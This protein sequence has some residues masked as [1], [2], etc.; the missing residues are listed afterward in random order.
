MPQTTR[1]TA[2]AA[3]LATPA[4]APSLARAQ[5][6]AG[7][8]W[9]TQTVRYINPYPPGGSTDILSRLFCARLSELTGQQFVV[10]NRSGSGGD[11]GLDAVAKSRPDGLTLGLGGIA[12]QAI[13]PTLKPSLPFHPERDFTFVSGIWQLP[14]LLVVNNDSPARTVPQLIAMMREAPGRF[15]YGSA[16]PGTTLHLSGAM[17][18]QMTGSELVHVPYRGE[19]PGLVDLM[20]GRIQ[21]MLAN[22]SSSIGFVREGKL[23]GLAVTSAERSP[24]APDLPAIAEFIPGFDIV[25]WTCLCGPAGIPPAMVARMNHWARQALESEGLR[26]AYLELG[27]RT[28]WTTPEAIREFRAAQEAK[29]RPIILASGARQD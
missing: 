19:A 10:E 7:G 17:F 24:A 5:G 20:A 4:F 16:G 15:S 27:A 6:N 9:P 12:S 22:F 1:R 2:L 29:L 11:V 14:N 3:L 21:M 23:R 28:W 13:S 18:G 8:D 26:R 25:S